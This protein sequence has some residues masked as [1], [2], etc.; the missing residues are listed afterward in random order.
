ML[1]NYARQTS[2]ILKNAPLEVLSRGEAAYAPAPE[3][4]SEIEVAP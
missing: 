4:M 3:A 1:A 2:E